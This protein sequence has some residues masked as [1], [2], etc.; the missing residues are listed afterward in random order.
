[1]AEKPKPAE[2]PKDIKKDPKKEE[3]EE[4]KLSESDKVL[5]ELI[6]DLTDE[7]GSEFADGVKDLPLLEQV[8][9]LRLIKKGIEKAKS[10]TK[11]EEPSNGAAVPPKQEHQL[12]TLDQIAAN[13]DLKIKMMSKGSYLEQMQKYIK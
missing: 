9:S 2:D 3:K 13:N 8:R 10:I 5:N 12:P 7:V 6:K 4:S 11:K 1:M